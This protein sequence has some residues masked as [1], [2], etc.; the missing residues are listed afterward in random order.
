MHTCCLVVWC[1]NP[2]LRDV[3]TQLNEVEAG[4]GVQAY[5]DRL[6]G[7]TGRPR[8]DLMSADK[9]CNRVG[10]SA[11]LSNNALAEPANGASLDEVPLVVE[12]A[13]DG[14]E[15]SDRNVELPLVHVD[16]LLHA[17]SRALDSLTVS[18]F[19]SFGESLGDHVELPIEGLV[20]CEG[21]KCFF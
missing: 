5:R 3:P 13:N 14:A 15:G 19:Q 18:E 17:N 21:S 1:P 4:S 16:S 7:C 20:P 10:S 11:N 9:L 12:P 8:V 2:P 6:P